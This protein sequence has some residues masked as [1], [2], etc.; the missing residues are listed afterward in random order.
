MTLAAKLV[1]A[2]GEVGDEKYVTGVSVGAITGI[3]EPEAGWLL[4][5]GAAVSRTTY[6]KLFT[7]LGTTYGAGDGSTTFNLPNHLDRISLCRGAQ[8]V[9]AALGALGHTHAI[10]SHA[11][12]LGGHG[13]GLAAHGHTL[14]GH[15][16]SFTTGGAAASAGVQSG[17]DITAA[18]AGH[19]HTG[20]TSAP[21]PD[22]TGGPSANS[23]AA[24]P[25]ATSGLSGTPV[26]GTADPAYLVVA[27]KLVRYA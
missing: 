21:S 20:G 26:T 6:A 15:G 25:D 16:H 4:C 1:S 5:N 18:T 14:S 3:Q 7:L 9:G 8:S 27:G 13:H 12:T 19:T 17:A 22:A 10:S 2:Q 11:H 23:G 24:S